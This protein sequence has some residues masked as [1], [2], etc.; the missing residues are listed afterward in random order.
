MTTGKDN[1]NSFK[2]D[3]SLFEAL[4]EDKNS[5]PGEELIFGDLQSVCNSDMSTNTLTHVDIPMAESSAFRRSP[6]VSP[7]YVSVCV[8]N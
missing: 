8:F 2:N 6:V 5:K 1:V 4:S 7:D 3:S